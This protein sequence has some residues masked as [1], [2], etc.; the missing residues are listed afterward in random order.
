[1]AQRNIKCAI[2]FADVAGSTRLYEEV[3]DSK[4]RAMIAHT[5]KT[6]TKLTHRLRGRVIKTI[7]DEVMCVFVDAD[8]AVETAFDIQEAVSND[9]TFG[10]VLSIRIGEHFGPAILEG[11]GDIFG[12]AVNVAARMTGIAKAGQ[13]IISEDTVARLNNELKSHTRQ[14][15]R[16][17]V[18]GK[19]EPMIIYEVIWQQEDVTSIAVLKPATLA[20]AQAGKIKLHWR[21]RQIK[22]DGNSGVIVIGRGNEADFVVDDKFASR[23]HV[24]IES[25]R[26]KFVIIDQ[27]T[28]G[29]YVRAGN[30]P[31]AYLKRE[32][33]PLLGT[34]CIG[35]GHSTVSADDAELIR[36]TVE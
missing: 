14:F 18:K 6:M 36:Y 21:D 15:D 7:G 25:R 2:M 33:L 31:E 23:T 8:S 12:D 10:R 5:I 27:S 22:L 16:T 24:R 28:N 35:L 9:F 11:D 26:G 32:D 19:K 4:A 1:M 13:I 3:G 17:L 30:D 29:T 20:G 34:G